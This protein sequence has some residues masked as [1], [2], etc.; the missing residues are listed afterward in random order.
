VYDGIE[1][2]QE[3]C[4]VGQ[5]CPMLMR[6]FVWAS[7]E[8]FPEPVAMIDH[9]GAG[10][11][12]AGV[13]AGGHVYHTLRDV[14]G[15]VIGLADANGSL[16]ERYTYDPYGRPLIERWNAVLSQWEQPTG[17]AGPAA[18]V[19]G[20]PF[21]WTGQR[22]DAATETYHFLYR[23]YSPWLGRWLQRDPLGYEGGSLNLLEY[24]NGRPTLVRDPLGLEPPVIAPPA[25]PATTPWYRTA[26]RFAV[27]CIRSGAGA[28][29]ICVTVLLEPTPI[30]DS[31]IKH[32]PPPPHDPPLPPPPGDCEPWEHEALQQLVNLWCKDVGKRACR[33][34]QSPDV[35]QR[36]LKINEK[37]ARARNW[38]NGKCFRG[39]D[40]GH[41]DAARN[42]WT[43]A[44]NCRKLLNEQRQTNQACDSKK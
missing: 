3:Y 36:N 11:G 16:V 5:D 19:F 20:N 27:R 12:G 29:M 18:S 1:T 32:F 42:A 23:T 25:S 41:Q 30:G 14:L 44:A 34:G 6:E 39:G 22:Y 4:V 9:T 21:L 24:V 15:S 26:G 38:I 40:K 10:Q 8:R 2:I 17:L 33:P 37:C 31:E 13:P 35:I 43:A 7:A 28:A